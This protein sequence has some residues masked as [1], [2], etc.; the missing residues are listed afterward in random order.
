M[1][2]A[3]RKHVVHLCIVL[4]FPLELDILVIGLGQKG[5]MAE[6]VAL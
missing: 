5:V 2:K 1:R 6:C 4:K 3:K